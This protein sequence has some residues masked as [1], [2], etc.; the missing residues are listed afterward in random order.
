MITPRLRIGYAYDMDLGL[1]RSYNGGSH[2]VFLGFDFSLKKQKSVS[3]R[4]L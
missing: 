4:Y 1:L 2:E 3:P